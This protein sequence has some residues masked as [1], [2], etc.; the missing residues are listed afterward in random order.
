M[1]NVTNLHRTA[2]EQWHTGPTGTGN[3]ELKEGLNLDCFVF[4]KLI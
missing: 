4:I 2:A 3:S 1:G